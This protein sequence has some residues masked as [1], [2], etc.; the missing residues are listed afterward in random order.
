MYGVAR[1]AGIIACILVLLGCGQSRKSEDVRPAFYFWKTRYALS[2]AD[3]SIL[4]KTNA[5]KLYLRFC[6]VD[7]SGAEQK[8]L[9]RAPLDFV[10]PPDTSLR[11]VPVVFITARTLAHLPDSTA[12]QALA[13]NI[14]QLVSAMCKGASI[15]PAEVQLD[16]DWT[17]T[18]QEVYFALLRAL[19]RQPS[20]E[21][22]TLTATIRLHQL[23]YVAKSGVP[24]VDRGMLMCYNMGNTRKP[25]P[26][27]SILDVEEA[28]EYLAN[29]DAYPLP[30][31]LA[32]PLFRWCV[33]F[34]DEKL[35]GILRDVQ[36][37]EV[38]Q[39]SFLKKEKGPLYRCSIDTQWH[40][41]VL[42][43]DDVVRTE[44]VEAADI[45]RI[46]RYASRRIRNKALSVALY[47]LDPVTCSKY[48]LDELESFFE[49][50][51]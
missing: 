39:E 20:L 6:D 17:A 10:Q 42:K 24:P 40:G 13:K 29:V 46:A 4:Q 48:S 31:D 51:R 8:I 41:Y 32:L 26:H 1:V 45:R 36:P 9:P 15:R 35:V 44:I 33:L 27:N 16:C 3:S 28:E 43:R 19:K 5:H 12:V 11:Y 14:A 50:C 34:R 18:K 38:A 23:K 30:L 49:A 7:W 47:H 2:G 22:K 21:K 25:G 37:Q